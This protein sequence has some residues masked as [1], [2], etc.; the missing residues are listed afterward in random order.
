VVRI[1]F[2]I[3]ALLTLQDHTIQSR[4]ETILKNALSKVGKISV[5][6]M[7]IKINEASSQPARRAGNQMRNLGNIPE[8]ALKGKALSHQVKYVYTLLEVLA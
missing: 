1:K 6:F 2:S 5:H 7:W 4:D 8:K 3:K